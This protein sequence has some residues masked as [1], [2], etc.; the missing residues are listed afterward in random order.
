MKN[1]ILI[2]PFEE[3]TVTEPRCAEKSV[4]GLNDRHLNE[5]IVKFRFLECGQSFRKIKLPHAQFVLSSQP[6]YGKSH[7]IGRLFHQLRG[8]AT[9]IYVRPFEDNFT[10]WKSILLKT[11]QEMNFPEIEYGIEKAPTQLETFAHG[12]IVHLLVEAIRHGKIQT[13]HDKRV[14]LKYFLDTPVGKVINSINNVKW[15][16]NNYK[17]LISLIRGKDINLNASA[18]SWIG[19]LFTYTYQPESDLREACLDWFKGGSIDADEA[20]QI[21]VRDRD[22]PRPDMS[23]SE[24]NEL[25]KQRVLDFCQLAGFFRPF[26]FCFDQTENYGKDESLAKAFGSVIQVLTDESCNQM[27][28]ITA[29]Q[30]VWRKSIA[31]HWERAYL[32]RLSEHP[33]ELEGL[34]Q[35]QAKELVEQRFIMS[36]LKDQQ[37]VFE[38]AGTGWL[39]EI[40]KD[41]KEIGVRDFL[42]ECSR[43]WRIVFLNQP[44]D[45]V[46]DDKKLP[47]LYQKC[48]EKIR[49][50][51]KRLVFDTNVFYWLVYEAAQGI[52]DITIEKYPKSNRNYFTLLWKLKDK[53][54]FFGFEPG[55]NWAR[56]Q[57]ISKESERYYEAH[58]QRIKVIFFRTPELQK[59]P[60]SR[61]KI[62][63]AL[64]QAKK[65]YLDI[66]EPPKP[67]LEKLYAAYDLYMD[68]IEGNIS[69]HR[70][71]VL[72]F[73][74]EALGK[75]WER[76]QKP[77]IIQE[78]KKIIPAKSSD[79]SFQE[80][81][82]EIRRIMRKE[83]FI[84]EDDLI[85]KMSKPVSLEILHELRTHITEIKAYPSA[86]MTVLLWQSDQLM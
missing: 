57:G 6:G 82:Q 24:S 44:E 16:H 62:A 41:V 12:I 68:A 70:H 35:V 8:R 4:S 79:I 14:L 2:N 76:I 21:G 17:Q 46:R 71:E 50:Q 84:S 29:N 33:L 9:M 65:Q 60:S 32:N 54:F 40:F 38:K 75:F 22:I 10:C 53:Q 47:D 74:R 42:Y 3:S 73:I 20:K 49:K 27:T 30:H 56:W 78:Q 39:N 43:R 64:E 36:S 26:V 37:L 72:F 28:V 67:E 18:Q 51:P 63:Q 1:D 5:L 58:R 23:S 61:W 59:I 69:F 83:K 25:C 52:S 80:L 7:L 66:I 77:L 48:I 81:I 86:S 55:S 19:A 45:S 13:K 11:V 31:P 85:K 34:K 15:I